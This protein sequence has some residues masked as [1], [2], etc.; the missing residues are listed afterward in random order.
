MSSHLLDATRCALMVLLADLE[1]GK[2]QE[3]FVE[4]C[5][6]VV[7]FSRRFKAARDTIQMIETSVQRLSLRLP[8]KVV[9]IF[10]SSES[11][12]SFERDT[13]G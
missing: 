7:A 1:V 6:C 11:D 12:W 5:R 4:L 8:P 2:S 13:N 10:A 3:A 9:T